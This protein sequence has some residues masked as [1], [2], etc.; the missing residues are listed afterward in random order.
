MSAIIAAVVNEKGGATKTTTTYAIGSEAANLGLRTL[1][2]DFDPQYASLTLAA[3]AERTRGAKSVVNAM[4]AFLEND[5]PG[6]LT[7]HLIA[8]RPHLDL[9][10][11]GKELSSA[12][13][14]LHDTP[15]RDRILSNVLAPAAR[16]YDLVLIDC[17]PSLG[18]LVTNALT[19]AQSVIIPVTPEFMG[20]AGLKDLLDTIRRI[21]RRRLNPDLSVAAIILTKASLGTKHA[22]K[23]ADEVRATYG[24]SIAV[25]G[26]VKPA[27]I[28]NEASEAGQSIVD[29]A[30]K[31][32]VALAYKE[33]T[34]ELLRSWGVPL[35]ADPQ[36]GQQQQAD[37]HQTEVLH[38]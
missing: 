28:V 15:D 9:L 13:T 30:P 24:E 38:G 6:P 12:E 19:A 8:L 23:V 29:Y 1:I 35:P 27:T 18:I 34:R 2:V 20:A 10:P 16:D 17:P 3:G 26:P 11:S 31:H 7:P 22:R 33:I 32:D 25:L 14:V 4:Q 21:K 36:D 37:E 5:E